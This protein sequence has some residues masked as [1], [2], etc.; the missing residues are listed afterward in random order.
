MSE[1]LENNF[2]PATE[3]PFA[4]APPVEDDRQGEPEPV[5]PEDIVEEASGEEEAETDEQTQESAEEEAEELEEFEW[6]GR[7]ISAPKGLKDALMMQ[8]DY[9]RKTQ[10]VAARR[11][12]L[13]TFEQS[14][15]QRAEATDEEMDLR[16]QIWAQDAYIRQ[17]GNVDWSAWADEDPI[18]ANKARMQYEDLRAQLSENKQKLGQFAETRNRE[19]QQ[20][21]AKRVGETREFAQ[22]NIKGFTP[23]IEKKVVD[24]ALAQGVTPAQLQANL[25]PVM[26]DI[27]H[28]AMLGEQVLKNPAAAKPRPVPLKTVSSRSNAP[29]RKTLADMNMDEY[30]K[31][32]KA[33]GYEAA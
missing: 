13:D 5:D 29:V 25:S 28:K 17:Y 24:F 12:E 4:A 30:V 6:E 3:Q 26:F 2:V 33:Q 23:E 20:D 32:R 16:A 18:A 9:T 22:K 31:A 19:A 10:E 14:L 21:F 7:T 1:D 15:K 27:L 11:K 8:A